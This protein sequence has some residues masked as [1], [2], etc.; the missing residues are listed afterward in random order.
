MKYRQNSAHCTSANIITFPKQN[1][2]DNFLC[3][4]FPFLFGNIAS[5]KTSNEFPPA[6]Q[7]SSEKQI[8]HEKL[9]RK[10][11][12]N[13]VQELNLELWANGEELFS[14]PPVRLFKYFTATIVLQQIQIIWVAAAQFKTMAHL[15]A[16]LIKMLKMLKFKKIVSF[17]I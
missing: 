4:S 6:L 17:Q 15:F 9:K 1:T 2:G 7:E 5:I 12:G 13:P 8:Y 16:V 14:H 10:H 11:F 3:V